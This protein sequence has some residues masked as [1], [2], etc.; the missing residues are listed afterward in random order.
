M[1]NKETKYAFR[2]LVYI[3]QQN[4]NGRRPGI[5]EIA[6]EIEAPQFYIA[7]ILQRMVRFGFVGSLKGKGGGFYFDNT[8]PDLPL[9]DLIVAIEGDKTFTACGF[10][11]KQCNGQNP[12]P[13]HAQYAPIREAIN[14]MV[15]EE[16]IQRFAKKGIL[17]D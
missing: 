15:S 10:G 3:Q 12:C 4:H 5:V 9:K 14:K 13:M 17:I 7:K 2:A 8:K 11:L 6:K 1:F 16:T